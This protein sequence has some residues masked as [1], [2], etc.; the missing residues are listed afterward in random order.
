MKEDKLPLDDSVLEDAHSHYLNV[1]NEKFEEKLKTLLDPQKFKELK[2]ELNATLKK[3]YEARAKYNNEKSE[4][5]CKE[6]LNKFFNGYRFPELDNTEN[7]TASLVQEKYEEY[8]KGI[9]EYLDRT[10]APKKCKL[11]HNADIYFIERVPKFLFDFFDK[12]VERIK[13]VYSEENLKLKVV[14]KQA[15]EQSDRV[16]A[17]MKQ[18]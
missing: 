3:D 9:K 8:R 15:Q 11:S 16:R 2:S 18:Q 6:L 5:R 13:K 1:V 7:V 10:K 4:H 14:S 12:L 17:T